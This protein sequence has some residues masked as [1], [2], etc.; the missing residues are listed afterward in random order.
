M[1]SPCYVKI[2]CFY[3]RKCFRFELNAIIIDTIIKMAIINALAF[4]FAF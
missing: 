1:F 2:S 4:S 3:G